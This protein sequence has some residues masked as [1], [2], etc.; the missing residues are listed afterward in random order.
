MQSVAL[1]PH[2]RVLSALETWAGFPALERA[3]RRCNDA[4]VF[5]AGGALRDILSPAPRRPRDYD[6]FVS[7]TGWKR[8][9][10]C[11]AE[12]GEMRPGPFGS[13]RW[14]PETSPECY[15]DIVQIESF[16]NG[17]WRCKDILDAL[18]QFD[19]TA[20]AIALDLH[21]AQLFDPQNGLR[22]ARLQ[23]IRAVR[24]DYPD[25]PIST[26]CPISRQAV[27]WI[28]LVHYASVLGF[29]IE[30]LTL[31]WLQRTSQFAHSRELF[32]RTFFPPNLKAFDS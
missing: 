19:F 1:Q 17:L 29:T 13:P 5:L 32:A 31:N 12:D 21:S 10:R 30:P 11:L 15:A 24:F 23:T 6:F 14:F 7:G 8:L 20:N 25:E 18:N 28:R 16:Y 22:D 27:I 3:I 9:I 26:T 2:P 4:K